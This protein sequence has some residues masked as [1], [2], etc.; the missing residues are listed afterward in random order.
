MNREYELYSAKTVKTL[1]AI[2]NA[3]V[4]DDKIKHSTFYTM[5][6]KVHEINFQPSSKSNGKIG[7]ATKMQ[8]IQPLLQ[9]HTFSDKCL[10]L[11]QIES[12]HR[13]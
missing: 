5:T 2:R 4:L 13:L 9:C 3:S 6:S 7:I 1:P 10:V 11:I 12:M 8:P